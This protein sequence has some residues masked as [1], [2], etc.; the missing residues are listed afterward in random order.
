MNDYMTLEE[1][2][3]IFAD[4]CD[5]PLW[6]YCRD[7]NWEGRKRRINGRKSAIKRKTR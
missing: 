3:E 7:R 4:A 2:E 6:I 5:L 1:L